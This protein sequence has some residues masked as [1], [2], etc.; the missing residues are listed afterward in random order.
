MSCFLFKGC[1]NINFRPGSNEY[2]LFTYLWLVCKMRSWPFRKYCGAIESK[3]ILYIPIH[4]H[5]FYLDSIPLKRSG[6]RSSFCTLGR[7]FWEY[8]HNTFVFTQFLRCFHPCCVYTSRPLVMSRPQKMWVER[9]CI[10]SSVFFFSLA[11]PCSSLLFLS[12]FSSL[13]FSHRPLSKTLITLSPFCLTVPLSPYHFQVKPL[14]PI[15]AHLTGKV[16]AQW[17]HPVNY[18]SIFSDTHFN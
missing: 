2:Y 15:P 10:P 18:S 11:L 5:P 9:F 4:L 3:V 17:K 1:F 16:H 13:S 8:C 14:V 7:C 6:R 12:L